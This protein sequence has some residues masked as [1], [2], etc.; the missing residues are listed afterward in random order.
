MIIASCKNSPTSTIFDVVKETSKAV[1]LLNKDIP[2]GFPAWLPKTCI[3]EDT[4]TFAKGI[5]DATK[6][7]TVTRLFFK[8]SAWRLADKP[9][10]R[11][12]LGMSVY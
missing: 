7:V 11:V 1:Q 2:N 8:P 12:S 3:G 5:I 6:D 4:T 10:K 9:W